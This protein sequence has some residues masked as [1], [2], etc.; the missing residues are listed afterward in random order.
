MKDV[1]KTKKQLINEL[2]D[3]R[4]R[5]AKLKKSEALH[6]RAEEQLQRA[7]NQL[8]RRVEK[9][10]A[11][12]TRKNDELNQK[13][14]EC[15]KTEEALKAS[16][17]KYSAIVENSP[18]I[19]YILDPEGKFSFVGGAIGS[20]LGYTAEELKGNHFTSIIY[21]ED[22]KKAEWRFNERRTG[23]RSTKKFEIRL[24]TKQ[25][26]GKYFDVKY[27]TV[28]LH[29]FG[30]Y[31]RPVSAKDKKFLGTYGVAREI[32]DLKQAEEKLKDSEE[33]YRTL[34]E[35]STDAILMMDK[36]RKIVSCNQAFLDLFGYNKNEI[37]GRSI[38]I[39][40]QSDDSFRSFGKTAYPVI[41]KVGSFMTEWEFERKDGTNITVETV[42][43]L[44]KSHDGAITGYV[45]IIRDITER[46]R[47]EEQIKASLQEK[48][49]ML[50]EIHH[51][52]KNN[53]QVISSLLK[54]QSR[55]IKNKEALEMFKESQSR[56]R[57]MALIHEKLYK[58]KDLAR[59]DSVEYIRSLT[60]YL[61]HTYSMSPS[62]IRLNTDIKDVFLAINTAIP[63][64]LIINELVSN[65]IKHAFQDGKGGEIN[66]ALH[67]INKNKL[68]LI[69]SD[70]G[71]GIPKDMDF[72]NT[73]SIGMQ[74]VIT[75]VAQLKG[76]IEL[77]TCPSSLLVGSRRA[78]VGTAFR[79]RFPISK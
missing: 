50:K 23:E 34:V 72:R 55:H 70:N 64:G 60:G 44:I 52:V 16:E 58:Y 54:L 31:D 56:L 71:I 6:K 3:L 76:T 9:R 5:I 25:G 49:V 17:K 53:M 8:E 26:K 61:L 65:A 27:L 46:K 39:I 15:K 35:S 29:A 14:A 30:I 12:L 51:R 20:L 57:L 62:L 22:V 7:H 47:S 10:I 21:P 19:I 45:A 37:E 42:T 32:T 66:I 79:I 59:I 28:K 38:R 18:D 41:E 43:S 4:K 69:V 24:T 73:E 2:V 1:D 78:S 36:E 75:L 74:L 13:I 40:H 67:H 77:D 11:E 48:E 33:R 68:E 63:C